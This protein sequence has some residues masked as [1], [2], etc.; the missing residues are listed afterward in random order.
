MAVSRRSRPVNCPAGAARSFDSAS[1]TSVMSLCGFLSAPTDAFRS[2]CRLTVRCAFRHAPPK[3]NDQ[4]DRAPQHTEHPSLRTPRANIKRPPSPANPAA[5]IGEAQG[6]GGHWVT[7]GLK[8]ALPQLAD[9]DAAR[10]KGGSSVPLAALSKRNTKH[11][12]P[13]KAGSLCINQAVNGSNH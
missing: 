6:R 2:G 11:A 12:A 4:T 9:Y 5:M 8:S 13:A 1:P 10:A 3:P 7:S